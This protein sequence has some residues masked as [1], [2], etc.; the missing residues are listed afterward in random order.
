V[1]QR[2]DVRAERRRRPGTQCAYRVCVCGART[3]LVVT[4]MQAVSAGPRGAPR[5]ILPL[6]PSSCLHRAS[7][8]GQR[9]T[10]QETR[11]CGGRSEP[12]N[13]AVCTRLMVGACLA[14]CRELLKSSSTTIR[15]ECRLSVLG[16]ELHI[17]A[18]PSLDG[19]Q[20]R[21]QDFP[22]RAR[23][24]TQSPAR[25]VRARRAFAV[26]TSAAHAGEPGDSRSS[27][28]LSR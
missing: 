26:L 23:L 28:L 15:A 1:P 10:P 4:P 12:T 7:R 9:Q 17:R 24:G 27:A 5:S 25:Y 19:D 6:T 21:S 16:L 11:E 22:G 13:R 18:V 8:A 20:I 3:P 14:H 2:W